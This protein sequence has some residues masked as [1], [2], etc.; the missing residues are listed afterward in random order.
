MIARNEN[1]VFYFDRTED[2][3]QLNQ[4]RKLL[5]FKT[6][7]SSTS[8]YFNIIFSGMAFEKIYIYPAMKTKTSMLPMLQFTLMYISIS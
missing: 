7:S 5:E 1:E 4:A 8:D 2:L 3:G 6:M